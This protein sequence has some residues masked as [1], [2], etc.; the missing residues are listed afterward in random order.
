MV[1]YVGNHK[2][3]TKKILELMN[4]SKVTEYKTNR[5][6]SILILYTSNKQF[7]NEIKKRILLMIASK[8]MKN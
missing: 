4:F 7:E 5:Q 2:D 6:K 1:L 8:R 3:S